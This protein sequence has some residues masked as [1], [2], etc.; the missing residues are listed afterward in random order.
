ML[1]PQ[2]S[3]LRGNLSPSALFLYLQGQEC[4]PGAPGTGAAPYSPLAVW[5]Q[6]LHTA[7]CPPGA[8]WKASSC[9]PASACPEHRNSDLTRAL[10]FLPLPL[11]SKPH[12]IELLALPGPCLQQAAMLSVMMTID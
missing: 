11:Y 5:G 10:S 3:H 4:H 1:Q 7:R 12:N 2:D 9:P 8:Q 6:W